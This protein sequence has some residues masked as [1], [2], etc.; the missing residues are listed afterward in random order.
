MNSN[1]YWNTENRFLFLQDDYN[2]MKDTIKHKHLRYFAINSIKHNVF[3]I[4]TCYVSLWSRKKVNV[5]SNLF[6]A[7]TIATK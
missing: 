7:A 6:F 3:I 2:A 4:C 5:S 1:N